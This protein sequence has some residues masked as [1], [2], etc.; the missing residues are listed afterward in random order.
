[1]RGIGIVGHRFLQPHATA[2]VTAECLSMLQ[3]LQAPEENIIAYSAIAEG[4]DSIFAA[5]AL[6]LKIPLEIVLPFEDYE[7][8]FDSE[9]ARQTYLQL[10]KAAAKTTTL[11]FSCR[12]VDAY[13][14]AMQWVLKRSDIVIVV[15][16]GEANGGRA[17]TADA[18][19]KI[20]EAGTDWIHIDTKNYT[21]TWY[22]IKYS[23]K[24]NR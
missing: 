8:D 17:G 19:K 3:Q 23:R 24:K 6:E 4:A 21:T 20:K 12:S 22:L 16:N 10:K 1:M 5:T 13:Y 14:E 15:W 7:N 2:F 11:P 9:T 18:V